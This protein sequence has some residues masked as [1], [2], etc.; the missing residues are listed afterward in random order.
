MCV[1]SGP[2]HHRSAHCD[3]LATT[4]SA[5][6]GWPGT[7]HQPAT[8]QL[9][10]Q[11]SLVWLHS[12]SLG[13]ALPHNLFILHAECGVVVD[14]A[15]LHSGPHASVQC[16][17]FCDGVMSGRGLSYAWRCT[18]NTTMPSQSCTL[19]QK[20]V[21]M[22]FSIKRVVSIFRFRYLCVRLQERAGTTA[23]AGHHHQYLPGEARNQGGRDKE[24][25]PAFISIAAAQPPTVHC[26]NLT[27]CRHQSLVLSMSSL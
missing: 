15:Q 25:C 17:M 1:L 20:T 7:R 23:R 19:Y 16:P 6:A 8:S 26:F 3:R 22:V 18:V 12:S 11:D 14:T 4:D 10:S 21:T 2:H 27:Y 24:I 5:G 9:S 13:T